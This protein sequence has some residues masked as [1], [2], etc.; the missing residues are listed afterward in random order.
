MPW[1]MRTVSV[2]NDKRHFGRSSGDGHCTVFLCP[3]IVNLEVVK[4]PNFTTYLPKQEHTN[5]DL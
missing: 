1:L 3:G 5:L 2:W 4:T